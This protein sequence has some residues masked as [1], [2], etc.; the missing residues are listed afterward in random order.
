M[1]NTT[2]KSI[3]SANNGM[4]IYRGCTHG[5]IYCDARSTCYQMKHDFEDIEV[6]TNAPELL[7]QALRSKKK[8][9]MIGTGAMSD[10]YLHAE[11]QLRLTRRC[12]ELIDEYEFG[13]AIQTKSDLI[14]RDLDLLKKIHRKTKCVVQITLTTYDEALCRILEPN[15]STTKRRVEVLNIM[16]EEGIPT[17]CWMTPILPFINDSEENIQ[18]IVDCC[19]KAKTY[20]ILNFGI[21]VTL[22][23]GDRQYYYKMLDQHFPGLKEKYIKTYGNSY[24]LLSPNHI[25]LMEII[26][27]ECNDNNIIYDAKKLFEYMHQFMDK[28]T[29]E[30]MSLFDII[31]NNP[32]TNNP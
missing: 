31:E 10:P 21:G 27:K 6:K 23:D 15:V 24:E 9:C 26:R 8:R 25:R 4:N 14:L 11:N 18:S 17:I 32:K 20:G 13:L 5:C 7:E 2:A 22:R 30:Q 12:L 1:H 19:K 16:K 28:S 3:L 29:G